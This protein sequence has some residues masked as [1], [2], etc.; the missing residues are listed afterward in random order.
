MYR[1]PSSKKQC[2]ELCLGAFMGY[3]SFCPLSHF[4]IY[5][6]P[7]MA[8]KIVSLFYLLLAS[9]WF[10]VVSGQRFMRDTGQASAQ[11]RA[12]MELEGESLGGMSREMYLMKDKNWEL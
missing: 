7:K 5:F 12:E 2:M 8:P 9:T 3:I 1:L 6:T 11:L 10:G 4:G